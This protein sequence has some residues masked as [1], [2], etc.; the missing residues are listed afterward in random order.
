MKRSKK[1][2]FAVHCLLNQNA[3]A[4][5]VAKC[6]GAVKEFLDYCIENDYGIV[7]IDCPQLEFEPLKRE[8]ETKVFYNNE[9]S[10]NASRKAIKKM[11]KQINIYMDNNYKIYGIFGVEGSPTCGAVK[12]HIRDKNGKSIS[13]AESGIFFEELKKVFKNNNWNINI[14]DWDIQAK[15]PLKKYNLK[16]LSLL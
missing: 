3:R 13:V 10:R 12:T 11:V 9:V 4:Q 1:I 7:P 6:P 16:E 14:Y 15:K 5:T 8:P 2:I